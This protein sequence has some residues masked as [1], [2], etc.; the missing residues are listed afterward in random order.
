MFKIKQKEQINLS[1]AF[2]YFRPFTVESCLSA[3]VKVLSFTHSTDS[4]ANL[5][6]KQTNKDTR[7]NVLPAIWV[8]LSPVKVTHEINHRDNGEQNMATPPFPTVV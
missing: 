3:S 6:W 8:S 1:T 2:L 5:S 7:R 4:N